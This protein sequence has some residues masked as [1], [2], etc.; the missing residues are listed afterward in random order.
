MKD[1]YI[2]PSAEVSDRAV[3]G[4]GTKIWHFAQVRENASIGENCVIGKSVYVDFDVKIG[5]GVKVQ[6]FVSIYHGAEI[7]DD[8]FIGPGVSFTN[9]L[10]PRAFI[11]DFHVHKTRVKKGASIGANSTIVCGVTIG[12]YAMVGAGS[13]V[14]EDVPDHA[15]VYG[16]PA[17][18]T[19]FVCK[20]GRKLKKE[21]ET[22]NYVLMI[23][24]ECKEET[25]IPAD[26]YAR[27]E[28]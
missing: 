11:S 24:T 5:N 19:G 15:L 22:D 16:N 27:I 1:V 23:C 20:C 17:R 13:V 26:T 8:V 7:E 28:K 6:N 3:I 18:L 21:K 9:D 10:Y 2:H 4:P 14:T 12:R 25:K